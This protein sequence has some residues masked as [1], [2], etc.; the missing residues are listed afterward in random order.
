ML[1]IISDDIN[2]GKSTWC[3]AWVKEQIEKGTIVNGWVTLP[4]FENNEKIGHDFYPIIN[5]EFRSPI[6]FSR[7]NKFSNSFKF[8]KFFLSNDVF[9]KV[10]YEIPLKGLFV[11]DE[12]GMLEVK[13]KGGFYPL[14]DNILSKTENQLFIVQKR[15]VEDLKRLIFTNRY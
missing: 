12:I 6:K 11:V 5:S 15:A 8:G 4:V 2:V 13:E 3:Y 14:I 7:L 10:I 9:K 1:K